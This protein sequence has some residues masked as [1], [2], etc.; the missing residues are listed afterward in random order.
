[1]C[2]RKCNWLLR[3]IR[4]FACF[5]HIPL[6]GVTMLDACSAFLCSLQGLWASC[7]H[8]DNPQHRYPDVHVYR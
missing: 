7:Y 4:W 6:L 8:S 5:P 1:M 3:N 2:T